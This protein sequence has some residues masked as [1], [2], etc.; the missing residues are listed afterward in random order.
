MDR[1]TKFAINNSRA[2]IMFL[3]FVVLMGANTFFTMPSQ[4]DPEIT[5][6][7]AQVTVYFPGMPT[8]LIENLIAKPIEKKIKE[9]P[10]IEEINTTVATGKVTIQ[11]KVY[12]IYYDLAPIWQDLRNK[13]N[14]MKG[15]LPEGTAGPFVNDDFGRVSVATIAMTGDGYDMKEMRDVALNLQD[16]IGAMSSVSK[17]QLMGIQEERIY[18]EVNAARLSQYGF[19]FADLIKQLKSQNIILPGGSINADDRVIVIEPSG[20]L[21]SLDEIKNI[22]VMVPG[23]DQVVYLQDIAEIRRSFVEP[24]SYAAFYNDKPTVILAVS[25]VPRY[26]IKDFGKEIT[27]RVDELRLELPLGLELDYATYQ[28]TLVE[29]AVGSAVSNLYQT[30]GVVFFVVIMFLGLRTGLIVSMIVPITIL[31]SFILMNLWGIDL[32]RMSIAA[33]II[34]LGLLVDNGIV[35][36][37]NIRTLMDAGEDKKQ[38]AFTAAKGL[39]VPLLTS[40]LTTIFAFMPLMLAQDVTGEYLRSLSQVIIIALLSSWFLAMYI[41][42]T[43]CYWFLKDSDKDK[44]V[45]ENAVREALY[46]KPGYVFYRKALGFLLN[47]RI[48]FI[49]LMVG[50]L[51]GSV[52][53]LSIIPKQSMPYSDRNQFII[54]LDLPAGTYLG[55]TER[56]TR[57]LSGWLADKEQ[58]PDIE[59]NMAYV[60]YGGPRFF[61][62]LSPPDPADNVA[63]LVVNTN[64]PQDVPHVIEKVDRYILE[65]MPDVS[66]RSKRMSLGAGEIGLVEY[67]VIGSDVTTLYRLGQQIENKMNSIKGSVG[68][69]DDWGE[70]VIRTRVNIDQTR[71][72]RAGVTSQSI[73]SS[74][75][76]YFDGITV[77]DY[78]E[79]DKTIP[80]VIRGDETRDDWSA[81][82]VL[83]V[84]SESG[85][86]VPLIQVA[87]FEGYIAPG[88]F[89]RYNQERTLTVSGKHRTLQATDFHTAIYPFVEALDLPEGYRI[90]IGGEVEGSAK[91]N[92]SLAANM[93]VALIGMIILLVLQFNSFLR[94]AI[95]MLT[96]PLVIIGAVLGLLVSGAFLSFTA[97]LGIYSLAGM[98]VNNGIILIDKIDIGRGDGLN[99]R[100]AIIEACLARLRPI[101]MTALTTILGLIPM[102]L[103]GGAMWFPMAVVIMGGLAVGSVL[104]LGFVPVLYSLFFREA[105]AQ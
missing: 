86:A 84:A 63:F 48:P 85:E 32:Q 22:Q 11:P 62:A 57:Q 72:R 94:P 45:D 17:V 3:A 76:A 96:I 99:V 87:D 82:R 35:I 103:F 33:I 102:A 41:T 83:P 43:L 77:S 47:V 101:L 29:K 104:T 49:A 105:K 26:N 30:V 7:N 51:I 53:L 71:A 58:N 56:V 21:K 34:A 18:L 6:R 68:V 95:I 66:G 52:M 80:I 64:T 40:S 12:D 8:D 79:G 98:I 38:A 9:I 69:T 13:M 89:A 75:N 61:L 16:K 88:K 37:E 23:S 54:Y 50:L 1:I 28:P 14:D 67:R 36:S 70:P 19:A 25:M 10:E 93:P 60:G 4:E 2:T 74:L 20:N 39:G 42:P 27:A 90:E 78:R 24:S 100:D 91:G 31:C 59:G 46:A 97:I 44:A 5:I 15:S 81:L 73:A 92:S 65:Q 55:E